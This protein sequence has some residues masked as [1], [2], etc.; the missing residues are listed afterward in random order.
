MFLRLYNIYMFQV[1]WFVPQSCTGRQ[2]NWVEFQLDGPNMVESWTRWGLTKPWESNKLNKF[3]V[4][5]FGFQSTI[6]AYISPHVCCCATKLGVCEDPCWMATADRRSSW[7]N[8]SMSLLFSFN[9]DDATN[10]QARKIGPWVSRRYIC[11]TLHRLSASPIPKPSITIIKLWFW[12]LTW[13]EPNHSY[14][15]FWGLVSF[16]PCVWLHM[17]LVQRL[18]VSDRHGTGAGTNSR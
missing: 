8:N 4:L 7:D 2:I 11:L 12:G 15:L 6:I 5:I 16:C 1:G 14:I 3:H 13:C 9:F 18:H 10:W 17:Q